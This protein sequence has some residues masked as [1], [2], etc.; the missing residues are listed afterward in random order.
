MEPQYWWSHDIH[1]INGERER[2]ECV[3]DTHNSIAETL[4]WEELCE[5]S[6]Y[7]LKGTLF[8]EFTL[9]HVC[10]ISRHA[11][12]LCVSVRW[13]QENKQQSFKSP[14]MNFPLNH[15]FSAVWIL[16]DARTQQPLKSSQCYWCSYHSVVV[17]VALNFLRQNFFFTPKF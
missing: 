14:S 12:R 4:R 1:S 3:A 6:S 10:S 8:I 17:F 7:A 16:W 11:T 15:F 13:W 9:V 2:S 5:T